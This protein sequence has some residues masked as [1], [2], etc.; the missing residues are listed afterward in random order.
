MDLVYRVNRAVFYDV[1]LSV[2]LQAEVGKHDRI[3]RVIS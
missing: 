2:L 1:G 3:C